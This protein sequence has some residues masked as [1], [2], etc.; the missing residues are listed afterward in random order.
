MAGPTATLF[1]MTFVCAQTRE[2]SIW[3]AGVH[4]QQNHIGAVTEVT[5]IIPQFL[6]EACG[7]SP[8][9]AL[10]VARRLTP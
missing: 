5:V 8:Q 4:C 2:L 10:E 9:D 1:V 3:S 7:P 6:V